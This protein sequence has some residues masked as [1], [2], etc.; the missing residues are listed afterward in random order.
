MKRGLL[1]AAVAVVGLVAP[2]VT[3]PASADGGIAGYGLSALAAGVRYQ[4]NSPGLLPTGDP[5]EG[6]IMELDIPLARTGISA[7]PVINAI[8]SP[9]YPGDTVAHLGTALVTLAP[10]FPAIPNDPVL[11]ESNYPPTPGKGSSTSF[12]QNG[13]GEGSSVAGPNGAKVVA[14]TVSQDIGGVIQIGSSS[15]TNDITIADAKVTSAATSI[16]GSITIADV[17]TIESVTGRASAVSDGAKALPEATLQIGRVTVAGQA[18]YIDRDGIHV[19]P[20]PAVG[21]GVIAGVQAMVNGLLNT[22]GISIRTIA[23]TTTKDAGLATAAAGGLAITLDRVVPAISIPGVPALEIPGAPP[24]ALGTPT[25]PA[26]I[27]VLLGEARVS[28]NATG[29]PMLGEVVPGL[30]VSVPLPSI[31]GTSIESPPFDASGGATPVPAQDGQSA[32]AVQPASEKTTGRG[33]PI[34]FVIFGAF[35]ALAASGPLLGYARWQL[36]EGRQR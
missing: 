6:N 11:A 33:I 34:G 26:H 31:E 7:G 23:P 16:S 35:V 15:A 18:S 17:I 12:G 36:L 19:S 1:L 10:Q 9:A 21:S 14:R 20:N 29:I 13:I 8:A 5:A 22:D 24:V 25:L 27:E 30:G 4:L 3:S 32:L 28:A 2:P